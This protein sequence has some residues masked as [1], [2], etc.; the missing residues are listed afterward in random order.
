MWIRGERGEWR[1]LEDT[2]RLWAALDA[3][4]GDALTIPHTIGMEQGTDW[5][6]TNPRYDRVM[7][8]YQG[9]RNAYERVDGP[10]APGDRSL[11]FQAPADPS[12]YHPGF[13]SAALA[14]GHRVGFIAS[15]DHESTHISYA[16]VY[17]PGGGRNDIF[18][19]LRRRRAYAATDRI[20]VDFRGG[21]RLMGEDGTVSA[22]PVITARV[23]GTGTL[24]WVEIIR[25]NAIIYHIEPTGAETAF[26]L[27][28]TEAASGDHFYYLRVMQTDEAMA[29]ASPVWVTCQP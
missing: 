9:A 21:G 13:A 26:V 8:I 16:A 12:R 4:G 28:D 27:V 25:D 14:Q 2:Q 5:R 10:K 24:A 18:E 17:A 23:I 3:Q 29:W 7:E 1:D 6:H 15:S 20:G 11:H 22:P 19:A